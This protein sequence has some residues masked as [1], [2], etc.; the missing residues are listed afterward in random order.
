[1]LVL[2]P[3]FLTLGNA[4]CGMM[5]IQQAWALAPEIVREVEGRHALTPVNAVV[6]GMVFWVALG[7]VF[8]GLD[9]WVARRLR[10]DSLAGAVLDAL[11]DL[12]TFVAAP[13]LL[14]FIAR[15]PGM[16]VAALLFASAATFR[17]CRFVAYEHA[18]RHESRDGRYQ[19]KRVGLSTP[20]AG[21]ALTAVALA[22][23]ALPGLFVAVMLLCVLMIW[24]L[25][26]GF[27]QQ[28]DAT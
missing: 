21:I 6:W 14:L 20:I 18:H 9:G 17:L 25:P 24:P 12:L 15:G 28:L 27:R 5:A 19:P 13:L 8:D 7:A 2:V 22:P 10:V 16:A 1:M 3:V 23:L 11:A 26:D 4:A